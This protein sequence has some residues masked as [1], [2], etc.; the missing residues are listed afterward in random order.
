MNVLVL[1]VFALLAGCG[2][3]PSGKTD[4]AKAVSLLKHSHSG[5]G[6][7]MMQLQRARARLLARAAHEI[8]RLPPSAF[9]KLPAK[10][11]AELERRRCTIPQAAGFSA[12]HN[13]ISGS[14]DRPGQTD[15]AVLCSRDGMSSVIMFWNS[16]PDNAGAIAAPAED[17]NWLDESGEQVCYRRYL[18]AARAD[19]M[20]EIVSAAQKP[21][22]PGGIAPKQVDHDGISDAMLSR[23][24]SIL[25]RVNRNWLE[26]PVPAV[27]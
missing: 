19:Y 23:P 8:K 18:S 9:P 3:P 27:R 6:E 16:L 1:A 26:F 20:K 13:V 12:P 2:N 10:L 14:F 21:G 17:K 22:L 5:A 24:S 4:P 15:W 11:R 7:E 25:Y